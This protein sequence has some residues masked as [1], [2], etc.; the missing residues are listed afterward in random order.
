MD[1]V[2]SA[3]HTEIE[4]NRVVLHHLIDLVGGQPVMLALSPEAESPLLVV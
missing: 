1:A 4:I 2:L 3:E